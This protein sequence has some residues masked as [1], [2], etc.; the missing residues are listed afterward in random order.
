MINIRSKISDQAAASIAYV[1][2][3]VNLKRSEVIQKMVEKLT[4]DFTPDEL[5][6]LLS[7]QLRLG[8]HRPTGAEMRKSAKKA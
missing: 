6:Y 7:G 2:R 3:N 5:L 4:N 1:A 8:G